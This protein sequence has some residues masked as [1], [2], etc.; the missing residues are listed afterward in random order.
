MREDPALYPI[1][2]VYDEPIDIGIE[3]LQ[4]LNQDMPSGLKDLPPAMGQECL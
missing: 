3:E 2:A 1:N 4:V